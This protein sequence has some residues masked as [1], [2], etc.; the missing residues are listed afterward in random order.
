MTKEEFTNSVISIEKRM[1]GIAFSILQSD[2]DCADAIQ[3]A[4]LLSFQ[5]LSTLKH[6]KYFGTWITRILINECFKIRKSRK[7]ET[8][9][10]TYMLEEN[11]NEVLHAEK[12]QV[13]ETI[14]ELEE[15]YRIPIIL[16][17]IEG[18]SVREIHKIL[19]ISESNVKVRLHRARRM[20]KELLKGDYEL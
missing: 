20:L 6:D 14:L 2:E 8:S 4:I 17:Y 10:E 3:N 5:N 9:Y 13:Y 11:G 1:Y 7:A 18:Y 12:S 16:H 15:E 19:D